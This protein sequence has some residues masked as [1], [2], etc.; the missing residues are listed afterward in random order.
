MK[1]VGTRRVEDRRLH[2]VAVSGC[3]PAT[4]LGTDILRIPELNVVHP[5]PGPPCRQG[6]AQHEDQAHRAGHCD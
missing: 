3:K 1:R 4:Y 5:N 2:S 6:T